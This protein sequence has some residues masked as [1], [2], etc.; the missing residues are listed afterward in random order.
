MCNDDVH[1]RLNKGSLGSV[2]AV[3]CPFKPKRSSHQAYNQELLF[4]CALCVL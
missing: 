4:T 3:M 2:G 1:L